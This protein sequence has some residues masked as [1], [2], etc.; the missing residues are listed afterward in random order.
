MIRFHGYAA[1][2]NH[3]DNGRDR[4]L[5]GAFDYG[6][7]RRGDKP[8][9]LNWMHHGNKVIGTIDKVTI[10]A[11]GLHVEASITDDKVAD[12]FAKGAVNGLS[13]G[14]RT[15]QA[16]LH[17]L[18]RDLECIELVEISLVA[19]PMQTQCRAF[20]LIDVVAA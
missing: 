3:R 2:F 16:E 13:I 6:L 12:A 8:F 17:D 9:A 18:G 14:Y 1:R 5:P 11:V 15:L 4:I 19:Q 10:D 20:P 7:A